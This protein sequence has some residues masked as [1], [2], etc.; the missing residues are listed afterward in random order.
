MDIFCSNCRTEHPY[1]GFVY[2]LVNKTNGKWYLG[3]HYGCENDGYTGSGIAYLR[4]EK[5]YGRSG[6]KREILFFFISFRKE[7]VESE[8][9]KKLLD[10][11]EKLLILNKARENRQS[12]NMKN[13]G[14]GQ[15]PV[16]ARKI[17]LGKKV[18]KSVIEKS[19][20]TTVDGG[21]LKG[22]KNPRARK[23]I[24]LDTEEIFDYARLAAKRIGGTETGI[25]EACNKGSKHRGLSWM[26][27]SE[28]DELDKPKENPRF[29]SGVIV[30]WKVV[31]MT[32]GK[33]YENAA[34]AS[35]EHNV[36]K[37]QAA[38]DDQNL[39]SGGHH[40]MRYFQWKEQGEPIKKKSELSPSNKYGRIVDMTNGKKYKSSKECGEVTNYN[41]DT[42]RNHVRNFYKNRRFISEKEW[43]EKGEPLIENYIQ[44]HMPKSVI[45]TE[46]GEVFQTIKEAAKSLNGGTSGLSQ[47]LKK[48][49]KFKG[50]MFKLN[51]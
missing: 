44:T 18:P 29:T 35:R 49:R 17:H 15:D 4:A 16:V 10:V 20:R 28:W 6:F 43:I 7:I 26:F 22:T 36:N 51:Q 41:E 1:L 42:V 40:W 3:S 2:K 45:N 13:K 19:R 50:V 47:A 32:D 23:V 39:T 38:V 12:Y 31:R 9:R 27:Y 34:I 25:S 8:E 48:G 5:T 37:I 30:N 24:C 14:L 46:T 33:V 11:E 21:L